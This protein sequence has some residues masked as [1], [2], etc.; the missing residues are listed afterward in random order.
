MAVYVVGEWYDLTSR[1]TSSAGSSRTSLWSWS[2]WRSRL[3]ADELGKVNDDLGEVNN[4]LAE[5]LIDWRNDF[6]AKA[7]EKGREEGVLAGEALMLT[8][9][10]QLKFGPLDDAARGRVSDADSKTLLRWADL[11]LTAES[12]D[13]VFGRQG[14]APGK[15]PL[16]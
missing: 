6:E 1:K 9:Q 4:M 5:N 8:R 14:P 10:L 3:K 2:D 15:A 16:C 13:D 12:L 11:V 7:V